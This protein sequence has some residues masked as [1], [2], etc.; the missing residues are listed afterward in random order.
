MK[1]IVVSLGILTLLGACGIQK[2]AED[3]H[4]E[5][6]QT[7]V[8][9]GQTLREIMKTNEQ[10]AQMLA[11]LKV[12]KEK[13]TI[14][15]DNTADVAK[16]TKQLEALTEKVRGLTADLVKGMS[17]T[18]DGV[19]LQ[20]LTLAL[21]GL[22]APANTQVLTPPASMLP[23]AKK[24]GEHASSEELLQ[25]V[26][27][28]LSNAK[29]GIEDKDANSRARLVA[30]RAASAVAAFASDAQVGEILKR[31]IDAGGEYVNAAYEFGAVRFDFIKGF[32]ID[33][34]ISSEKTPTV[35]PAILKKASEY[36]QSLKTLAV[37]PYASKMI[38]TVPALIAGDTAGEFVDYTVAVNADD[39]QALAN[40][41]KRRF[42]DGLSAT[43]K[44]R[45]DVQT[46][47]KVFEL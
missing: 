30:L 18:N 2:T 1:R 25:V 20:T 45:A 12:L 9:M 19:E 8:Q 43:D 46:W 38:V 4:H 36:F 27:T 14:A 6:Q 39:L 28:F 26:Y 22:T 23:Y 47:L 35:N 15:G 41:A 37:L 7:N 44:S 29:Y 34:L 5:V 11:E 40:K 16:T 24:F 10:M 32:L 13:T 33:P 17:K 3:T 21:Q 42:N 31:Q